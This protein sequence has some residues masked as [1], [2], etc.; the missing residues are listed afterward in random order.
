MRILVLM[1]FAA[2]W[3]SGGAMA[4]AQEAS[5]IVNSSASSYT[6]R[7]GDILEIDVWGHPEFS[8][9]FQV[10]E[11]GA[12]QYPVLGR[13]DSRD[14]TVAALRQQLQGG[15]EELPQVARMDLSDRMAFYVVALQACVDGVKEPS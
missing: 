13:I 11:T 7:P 9:Q 12:L 6:L 1:L 2:A 14:M 3:Q 5:G 10:D 8:G 15:L 4:A